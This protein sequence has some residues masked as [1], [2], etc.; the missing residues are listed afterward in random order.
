[1][2]ELARQ[3]AQRV[4]AY[5][6]GVFSHQLELEK[7]ALEGVQFDLHLCPAAS[8][9]GNPADDL[10][11]TRSDVCTGNGLGILTVLCDQFFR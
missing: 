2:Q 9:M 1:M 7:F 5:R 4:T 11:K 6:V 8:E 3:I 10:D